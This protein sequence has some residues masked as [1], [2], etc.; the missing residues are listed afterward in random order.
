MNK[1]DMISTIRHLAGKT[2]KGYEWS[3]VDGLDEDNNLMITICEI[4]KDG[5]N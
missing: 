3:V 1:K 4:K 5:E 2:K